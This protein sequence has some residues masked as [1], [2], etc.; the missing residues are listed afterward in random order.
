MKDR[1][2]WMLNPQVYIQPVSGASTDRPVCFSTNKAAP[3]VLQLETRPRGTGNGYIQSRLVSEKGICQP[4]WCLIA[5]C[6][7]QVNRQVAR[8]VMITPLWES[9]SWYPIILVIVEDFPRSFQLRKICDTSVRTGLLNEPG[10]PVPTLVALPGNPL[11]HKEYL[12]RLQNSFLNPGG[13]R[14]NQAMICCLWFRHKQH[15]C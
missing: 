14:L 11:H 12:Q 7:S 9:Q 5:C 1:C 8:V 10:V 4:P 3:N 13:P 6:L 15:F 2:N